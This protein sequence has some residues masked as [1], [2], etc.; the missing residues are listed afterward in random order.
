[1]AQQITQNQTK[2]NGYLTVRSDATGYVNLNG[3][4][5]PGN[6]A[7][8]TVTTA[9]IAGIYWSV[10]GTNRWTVSRGANV[11]AQLAGSGGWNLQT[12]STPLESTLGDK[13]ANTVFALSGGNGT[14]LIHMHK[15]SG[16]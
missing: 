7:G 16:E 3:G 15:Q 13:Q 11:V 12:M 4:T 14:V 10:T 6:S 2:F 8:E 1:M 5:N 9:T